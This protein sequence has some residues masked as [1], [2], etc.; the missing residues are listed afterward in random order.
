MHAAAAFRR[1]LA[2]LALAAP[3]YA[4]FPGFLGRGSGSI[5][6]LHPP[7]PPFG[8]GIAYSE[9]G[10]P[11]TSIP[12]V[13]GDGRV[14]VA[15]WAMSPI[16]ES[17]CGRNI[18]IYSGASGAFLRMISPEP[19]CSAAGPL[20]GLSD[21][22]G[23]G[24][25]DIAVWA[26]FHGP[27]DTVGRVLV[28]S[29]ASGQLL[30]VFTL[31]DDARG[32]IISHLGALGDVN[33]DGRGELLVGTNAVEGIRAPAPE[34][35]ARRVLIVS[36]ATG[37]V[38]RSLTVPPEYSYAFFGDPRLSSV[39]GAPDM[40]GDGAPDVLAGS[41][42]DGLVHVYSGATGE[43]IRTIHAFTHS[44]GFGYAVSSVPDADGDGVPDVVAGAPHCRVNLPV[45]AE[46]GGRAY[47]ISG[48]TGALLF[49][50]QGPA[51]TGYGF[52][53]S[54][55][56]LPDMNGDGR[57]DFAV[58]GGAPFG[59]Y[60]TAYPGGMYPGAVYVYSGATG[61]LLKVVRSPNPRPRGGFG[62]VI[63]GL[64]DTNANGRGDLLVGAPHEASGPPDPLRPAGGRA[65]LVRY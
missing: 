22:S 3:A 11:A 40:T 28:Y 51:A 45:P 56:G 25:G 53:S 34:T 1:A 54:V 50:R 63:I 21:V 36:G 38:L 16:G 6:P 39:A 9:F 52:G 18:F 65:Y 2:V 17:G 15:V 33:G 14:D 30:R 61:A 23:D 62:S 26:P 44:S 49:A 57:G 47:L 4:Q 37:S 29:G 64:T 10:A 20:A 41:D 35:T 31:P 42:G 46:G 48:R 27:W 12:D 19:S 13:N 24:R 58:T 8:V 32:E 5:V 43:L 7:R 59:T 60:G 55:T